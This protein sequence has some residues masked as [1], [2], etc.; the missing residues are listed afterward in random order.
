MLTQVKPSFRRIVEAPARGLIGLGLTPNAVTLAALAISLV[1]CALL[2]W[3]GW[4]L[5]FIPLL[6]LSLLLDALDGP[7]ARL[8]GRVTKTGGYLDA[9]CD[10]LAD[11]GLCL[12][13]AAATDHWRLYFVVALGAGVFSYAKARAE[14]EAPSG[15]DAWPDLMERTERCAFLLVSAFAYGL[16]PTWTLAGLDVLDWALG[17]LALLVY[18]SLTQRVLRAVKRL[19]LVDRS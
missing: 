5:V 13:L 4:L 9:L 8:S 15:N 11:G 14:M 6:G 7:V 1:L 12:A 18:A 19:G 3:T 2:A 10:R 17:A 16:F